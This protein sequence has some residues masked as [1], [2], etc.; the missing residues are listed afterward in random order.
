MLLRQSSI[1]RPLI[2][3]KYRLSAR[4]MSSVKTMS[5]ETFGKILADS[6]KRAEF[7]IVDVREPHELNE[8]AISGGDVVNLP[9]SKANE[10]V[11]EMEHGAH[12][13]DNEKPTLCLCHHGVRS[14]RV[15][16]FLI[17]KAGFSDVSNI[18]GGIARYALVV[19]SSVGSY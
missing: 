10:W 8:A 16:S 1:C 13:L 15:A 5:V 9:L 18:D 14:M 4:G 19:D 17:E 7:Q 11:L 2:G 3:L 12:S 6:V